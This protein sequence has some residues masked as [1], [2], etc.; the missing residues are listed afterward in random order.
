M[1]KPGPVKVPQL[2]KRPSFKAVTVLL[3]HLAQVTVAAQFLDGGLWGL[4]FA[5]T[6]LFALLAVV[7]LALKAEEEYFGEEVERSLLQ[8]EQRVKTVL[9][10]ENENIESNIIIKLDPDKVIFYKNP[11]GNIV[12]VGVTL[13]TL[14]P[15]LTLFQVE[16]PQQ[17]LQQP[18]QP[19]I[20]IVER[21]RKTL[22]D[23]LSR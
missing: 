13:E 23:L 18:Q 3:I 5:F 4:Y 7:V 22:S 1:K 21:K 6:S 10:Q 19:Q 14:K 11:Y 16:K 2:Y 15:Y 17:Q 12:W 20:L 9:K 8:Q